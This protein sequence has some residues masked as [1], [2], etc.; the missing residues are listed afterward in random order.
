MRTRWRR[1]GLLSANR[2]LI[3]RWPKVGLPY[4]T[5]IPA[6]GSSKPAVVR[7]FNSGVRDKVGLGRGLGLW[8]AFVRCS[9]GKGTARGLDHFTASDFES[10]GFARSEG[11]RPKADGVGDF[12]ILV[13]DLDHSFSLS[14]FRSGWS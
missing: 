12:S 9:L 4:F 8:Q 6:F 5:Q 1:E 11:R 7:V 13:F 10:F 14:V 3:L 2:I